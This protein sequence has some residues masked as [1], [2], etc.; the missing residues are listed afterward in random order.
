MIHMCIK[1]CFSQIQ[2]I[3]TDYKDIS[4]EV[5]RRQNLDDTEYQHLRLF[6][7]NVSLDK[8]VKGS[9]MIPGT[10]QYEPRIEE[11]AVTHLGK[12]VN[13]KI[14]CTPILLVIRQPIDTTCLCDM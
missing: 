11:Q 10:I 9:K 7:L 8:K 3:K 4:S 2:I 12:R 14:N 13:K 1:Y 5:Q 6:A